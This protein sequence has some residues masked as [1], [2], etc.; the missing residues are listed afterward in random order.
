[1]VA[2]ERESNLHSPRLDDEMAREV[3]PLTH[4][5]PIE[6]RAEE[7][8]LLE[9]A[10]DDEPAPGTRIEIPDGDGG[11]GLPIAAIRERA[12][13]ARHLRPSIFPAER[14][15][16]VE[17]ASEE[18]APLELIVAL[19]DLPEG[20]YATTNEIWLA[21]GGPSE[22]PPGQVPAEPAPTEPEPVST[23]TAEPEPVPAATTEPARFEFRFDWRFRAAALLFG[24]IPQHTF[25]TIEPGPNGGTLHA[26][27]GLWQ[28]ETVLDNVIDATRTGPYSIVKTI[29][30]AHVSV[31]DGGLTFA[32]N[33]DAGVCLRFAEPVRGGDPLG[34]LHH[35]SLTVTVDDPD[36][37]VDALDRA[38]ENRLP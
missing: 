33:T 21:L 13:L 31:A 30:P 20:T 16:I 18:F 27:F 8:R 10:A 7:D 14:D 29:G 25:V 38:R 28:I 4:G 23:A 11:P 5:A 3:A 32:T 9:D 34:L 22:E 15:A 1:M 19:R 26:S 6:T 2:M 12:E 17:C 35:G 24:V 37:L 36:A